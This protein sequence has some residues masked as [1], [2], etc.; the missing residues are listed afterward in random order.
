MSLGLLITKND[1][2]LRAGG[3]A[4]NFQ[5]VFDDVI[6]MKSFL[7][8]TPD[9]DL[10]ALG[11]TNQEVATLKTAYADLFQLAGIWSGQTSL[12]APKDFRTFVRQLWG[13]GAL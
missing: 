8:I 9:A 5:A 12:A 11:Y 6:I 4:L 7:D 13:I 10:V 3:I 2:D 1:I